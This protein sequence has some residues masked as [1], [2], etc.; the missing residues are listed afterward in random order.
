M[1]KFGEV[2]RSSQKFGEVRR[3]LQKFAEV[4]V[5]IIIRDYPPAGGGGGPPPPPPPPATEKWFSAGAPEAHRQF[6]NCGTYWNIFVT[7]LNLPEISPH[8]PT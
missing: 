4:R 8:H 5:F 3:S 1:E 7:G 2:R 6:A